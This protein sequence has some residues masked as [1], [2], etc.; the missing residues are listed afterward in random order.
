[1]YSSIRMFINQKNIHLHVQNIN[2]MKFEAKTL[3]YKKKKCIN[4]GTHVYRTV[5]F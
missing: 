3:Q 2:S 5:K 4:A 1:M